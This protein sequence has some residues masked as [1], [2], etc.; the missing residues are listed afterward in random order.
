MQVQSINQNNLSNVGFNGKVIL[1]NPKGMPEMILETL[2]SAEFLKEMAENNDIV[3]RLN[4]KNADKF[5]K[6]IYGTKKLFNLSF[7]VLRE[8]SFV[9]KIKDALGLINRHRL[10]RHFYI[11][12]DI[13]KRLNDTNYTNNLIQRCNFF[14]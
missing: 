8:N 12:D 3:V 4:K 5:I 1:K 14:I 11:E 10:A 13:V 6:R 7:S 9:D 2:N